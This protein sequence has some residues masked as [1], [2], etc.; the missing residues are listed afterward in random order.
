MKL[1]MLQVENL[2]SVLNVMVEMV[3]YNVD[4]QGFGYDETGTISRICGDGMES[5][6]EGLDFLMDEMKEQYDRKRTKQ[7]TRREEVES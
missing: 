2:V 1:T 4:S 5:F 7:K 3:G 6:D